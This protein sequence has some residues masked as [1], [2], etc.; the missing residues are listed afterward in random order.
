MMNKFRGWGT[1]FSFT[2]KQTIDAIGFKIGT[3]LVSLILIAFIVVINIVAANEGEKDGDKEVTLSP[4]ETV[5][6]QDNSGI[7]ETA[8]KEYIAA[9]SPE[10]FGHIQ[11]ENVGEG[12]RNDIIVKAAG[13]SNAI[14]VFIEI[15]D[16]G[17][18]I[19]AVIPAESKVT[20]KEA[21][22]LLDQMTTAFETNKL[23]QS[24]ISPEQLSMALNPVVTSHSIIGESSNELVYVIKLIAPM[25]FSLLLYIMLILYGQII[26]KS[27]SA[28]KT[29]KLMETLL[30]AIHPY[31]LITGKILG[32]VASALLQFGIWVVAL[33]IGLYGGNAISQQLFPGYENSIV[34]II[35]FF[36]DNF[37]ETAL[38]IPSFIVAMIVMLVGF[39]FY[40]VIAGLAGCLV[41]KPEEVASTQAIFQIP[42]VISFLITYL[43]PL[44][45]KDSITAIARYV[46]FT[47]PFGVPTDLITGTIGIGEGIISLIILLVFSLIVT[48]LSARIYQGLVLYTGQKVNFKL[49]G[50]ILKTNK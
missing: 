48:M 35:N 24:G 17:Y 16:A 11:F 2:F 40:C 30:T 23:L 10:V 32:V 28:E 25:I 14:A 31:A 38:S 9:S 37:S 19:E 26:S 13:T 27:V 41:S 8:Y 43:A 22:S 42:I 5:Y 3:A 50:N 36:Q 6:V 18:E 4:I 1:V 12:S 46:P 44:Y 47:A 34:V 29:S 49:I 45:N 39:L 21:K 7:M 33:L 15:K 20:T